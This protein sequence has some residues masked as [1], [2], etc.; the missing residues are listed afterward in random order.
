MTVAMSVAVTTKTMLDVESKVS[1]LSLTL[2]IIFIPFR[3][4][5]DIR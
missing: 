4:N 2:R 3:V 1:S 5:S